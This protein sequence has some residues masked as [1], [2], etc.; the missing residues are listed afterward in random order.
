MLRSRWR[1]AI[2]LLT[3]SWLAVVCLYWPTAASMAA[4]WWRSGTFAHGFLVLPI[5][6]YVIATRRGRLMHLGPSAN[7]WVLPLLLALACV[8][9]AGSLT[10]VLV[11]QQ[12]A[13]VGALQCLAWGILGTSV[14]RALLFPLAFL[15]FAVPIG[16]ALVAPLQD[17]TAFFTAHAVRASGV[18]LAWEGRMLVTPTARWHVDEACSGVRYLIPAVALGCLFSALTYRSWSRRL[19]FAALCVVVP[20]LANGARA[21]GIVMLG[22]LTS[23]RLA[24]GVDHQ[25]YGWVFFGLVMYLLFTLGGRWREPEQRSSPSVASTPGLPRSGAAAVAT[26]CFGVALLALAPVLAL[27]SSADRAEGMLVHAT[28]PAVRSPW[29]AVSEHAGD[30]RPRY[31][32]ANAEVTQTY[33]SEGGDV[34]L[35]I[36]YYVA[37][38]QGAE[39]VNAQNTLANRKVWRTVREDQRSV[40][41]DGQTVRV[42]ETMLL[43]ASGTRRLV[44]S[45]Y[46][47][48]D[49]FTSSTT[50]AKLLRARAQLLGGPLRAAAVVVTASYDGAP[51][52]AADL[53]RDFVDH[54]APWRTTLA[55]F[56][57]G[58]L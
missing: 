56:V 3:A 30:W 2:A 20:I 45:W 38:R 25:I 41:I 24:V 57:T 49:A 31:V 40:M 8:W 34:D 7:P 16:E 23:N 54:S 1:L 18:P 46:W 29:R 50:Y 32:G 6:L 43:S 21:Y 48:A 5:S 42:R 55:G 12:L 37:E 22:H 4:T 36:A 11:L 13:L 44:W 19:G 58:S 47:V 14:A 33:R 15:L 53:L 26:A 10:N 35:Y 27:L 17:F 51:A 52:R 28:P 39:M 9:L